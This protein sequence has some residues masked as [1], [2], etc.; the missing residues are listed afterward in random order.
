MYLR[1][2]TVDGWRQAVLR[3][4]VGVVRG[5]VFDSPAGLVQLVEYSLVVEDEQRQGQHA[6]QQHHGHGEH[7]GQFERVVLGEHQRAHVNGAV[8]DRLLVEPE[9]YGHVHRERDQPREH[10]EHGGPPGRQPGPVRRHDDATVPVHTDQRQRP[11]QHETADQ[12]K[13]QY[14]HRTRE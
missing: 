7:D 2:G 12:L 13:Q 8:L 10:G 4:C 3:H 6:G 1:Y 11:Q 9:R 5:R 14:A